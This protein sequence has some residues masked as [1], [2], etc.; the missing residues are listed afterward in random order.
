MMNKKQVKSEADNKQTDTTDISQMD[1]SQL[2]EKRIKEAWKTMTLGKKIEYLWMYYKSWLVGAILIIG[3]I[4]VGVTMYKGIHTKVLLNITIVGGNNLQAEWLEESFSEYAGIEPEDGI[5]K[6]QANLSADSEDSTSQIALSTLVG[7]EAVD[8]LVC[9]QDIYEGFSDQDGFLTVEEVLGA[10]TED[11]LDNP[12]N[13]AKDALILENDNI[14]K[15]EEMIPYDNAYVAVPVTSKN[16][17]M[18]AR[19]L[20]YLQQ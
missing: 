3:V 10:G 20:E 17:D 15:R 14:L 12:D 1:E 5:I 4:C 19:F 11:I 2:N 13:A 18:A 8:V 16:R 7:A 9:P 6:I